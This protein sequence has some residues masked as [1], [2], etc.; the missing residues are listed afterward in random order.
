MTSFF[1]R[2]RCRRFGIP[3]AKVRYKKSGLLSFVNRFSDECQLLS[4]SKG[5]I[6]F[7]CQEELDPG[8][9]IILLLLVPNEPALVLLGRVIWQK[10]PM[11]GAGI[12]TG[13][14]FMPFGGLRGYNTKEALDLLRRLDTEYGEEP[15]EDVKYDNLAAFK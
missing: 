13:I 9:K 15:E 10:H 14:E 4:M 3:G 5:G 8:K 6:G 7:T 2:R 1:E 11:S 12:I